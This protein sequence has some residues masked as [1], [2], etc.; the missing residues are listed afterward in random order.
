MVIKMYEVGHLVVRERKCTGTRKKQS[1]KQRNMN[2]DLDFI[3][4]HEAISFNGYISLSR[5]YINF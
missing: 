2:L 1:N 5:L 4:F 3:H